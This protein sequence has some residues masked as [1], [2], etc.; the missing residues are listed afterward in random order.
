VWCVVLVHGCGTWNWVIGSPGH[1]VTQFMSGAC[2]CVSSWIRPRLAT[3]AATFSTSSS[4]PLTPLVL[5]HSVWRT[6]CR[7]S[8]TRREVHDL[9]ASVRASISPK[10]QS[11]SSMH[12]C[13]CVALCKD[14]SL[15]RG[16][17]CARSL[18]SCIPRSSEDRSS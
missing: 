5:T 15:Q 4:T 18:A 11:N 2:V 7:P 17:F 1:N 3:A 14:I 16:R 9:S 10:L 12:H 13:E 6:I 8:P